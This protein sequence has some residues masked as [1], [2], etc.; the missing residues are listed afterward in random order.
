MT[1][2]CAVEHELLDAVAAGRWPDRVDAG[3]G[4]HVASCDVCR[5][6]AILAVGFLEERDR[7]WADVRVPSPSLVWW[8]AQLR[9]RDEAARVAVRPIVAV[10]M[11]AALA[12]FLVSAALAPAATAWL[13]SWLGTDWWSI[14]E[15]LSLT[16]MLGTAAYMTLPLLAVGLWLVL[17]PVIVF[18]TLED[19]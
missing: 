2:H 1:L 17:A 3:L 4:Q 15:N 14:P 18:L 16:W 12:V 19:P 13:R 6:V 10:Q 8:R 9:A 7:A 5:D 11:L